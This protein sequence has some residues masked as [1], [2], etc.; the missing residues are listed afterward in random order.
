MIITFS[1]NAQIFY[2][3][4]IFFSEQHRNCLQVHKNMKVH[5]NSILTVVKILLFCLKLHVAMST[6]CHVQWQQLGAA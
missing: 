2:N 6:N 3:K 4:E 1:F 5:K